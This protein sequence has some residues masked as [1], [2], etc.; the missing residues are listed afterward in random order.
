MKKFLLLCSIAISSAIYAQE[1]EITQEGILEKGTN[2]DFVIIKS[3]GKS[4]KELYNSAVKHIGK[5]NGKVLEDEKYE[6]LKWQ[7]YVPKITYIEEL[8]AKN[9]IDA[10]ITIQLSFKDNRAKYE[11]VAADFKCPGNGK[12]LVVR[13]SGMS[14][15]SYFIYRRNGT[16]VETRAKSDIEDFFKRDIKSILEQDNW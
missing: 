15:P 3:D 2:K 16:L 8:L 13:S 10:Y 7:V 4:A 14:D 6:R 1:F 9:Y 12:N 11:I 5:I